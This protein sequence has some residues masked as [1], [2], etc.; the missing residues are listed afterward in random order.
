M[1]RVY[2]EQRDGCYGI[3]ARDHAT[4]SEA[5]CA[6]VSG[7]MYALAGYLIN[8]EREGLV[9]NVHGHLSP[10]DAEQRWEG[11]AEANAVYDLVVIG[12]MQFARSYPQFV[13]IEWKTGGEMEER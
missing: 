12:L 8:A 2:F 3:C 6:A 4:G 13:E 7:L 5:A 11:G 9:Q 1:T 10:G